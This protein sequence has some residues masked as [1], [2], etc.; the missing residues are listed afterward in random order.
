MHELMFNF[1]ALGSGMG[2]GV[3]R[4]G[5]GCGLLGRSGAGT[6]SGCGLLG[7][8][9]LDPVSELNR[10]RLVYRKPA[11]S[12]VGVPGIEPPFTSSFSSRSCHSSGAARE[13]LI[14]TGTARVHRGTRQRCPHHFDLLLEAA[15]FKLKD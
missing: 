4:T 2:M 8:E 6:G 10:R 9:L 14:G 13:W 1:P 3:R 5:T 7:S 12:A 15:V 11:P